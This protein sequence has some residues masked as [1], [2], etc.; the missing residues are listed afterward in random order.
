MAKTQFTDPFWIGDPC[1]PL[2]AYTPVEEKNL[3]FPCCPKPSTDVVLDAA[4][5]SGLDM[6][7]DDNLMEQTNALLSALCAKN[8]QVLSAL[9]CLAEIEKLD[10]FKPIG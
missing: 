7:I 9:E 4:T 8:D 3:E 10:D 2:S 5:L 1:G 6:I